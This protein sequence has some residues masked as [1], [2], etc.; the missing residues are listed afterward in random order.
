[1]TPSVHLGLDVGGTASRWVACAADGRV[2]ARGEATGATGHIFNPSERDRLSVALHLVG[3]ALGTA[4]LR[5][6]SITAGITG[7]GSQAT[8]AVKALVGDRFGVSADAIVLV[9]DIVLA[10]MAQFE[11]GEGHLVSAGTGS[12][13]VH[14]AASGQTIRVGGRGILIDDGGAGSW[15]ALR[16]LDRVYRTYDLHGSFGPVA[17]LADSLFAMIGGQE[18]HDVRQFVYG[19]DRGRIGTLAV[20]VAQAAKAGDTTALAILGE[21][22][23]ELAQLGAALLARA[24]D[25]PIRFV[26]GVLD[27]HPVIFAEIGACLPGRAVSRAAGDAALAGAQL[28]TGHRPAWTALL[29]GPLSA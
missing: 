5:P 23:A 24:G 17:G 22:G 19:G 6:V 20:A 10:Y 7:Y 4:G 15:I 12:I 13:G 14:V 28:Q 27:L 8:D 18:W 3:E 11:P 1:M 2:L 16:A 25:H 9:D 29:D 26:G 21:A